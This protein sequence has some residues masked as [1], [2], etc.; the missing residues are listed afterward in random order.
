MGLG[1][2][3]LLGVDVSDVAFIVVAEV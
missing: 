2:V 1:F 3:L